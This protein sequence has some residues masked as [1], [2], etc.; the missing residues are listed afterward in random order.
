MI[1]TRKKTKEEI[2]RPVKNSKYYEKKQNKK[3]KE[4]EKSIDDKQFWVSKIKD[5]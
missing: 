4:S 3:V 5:K 1:I 2:I